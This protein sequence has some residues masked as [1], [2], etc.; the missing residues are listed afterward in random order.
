MELPDFPKHVW[1]GTAVHHYL[2]LYS[3]VKAEAI[4]GALTA[5]IC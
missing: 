5:D 1:L 4:I 3:C 2:A